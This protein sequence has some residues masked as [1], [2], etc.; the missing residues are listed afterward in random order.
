MTCKPVS[1]KSRA[2]RVTDTAPRE[3]HMAAVWPPACLWAG[4]LGTVR[5]KAGVFVVDIAGGDVRQ[6]LCLLHNAPRCRKIN[7]W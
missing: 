3:R 4:S 1:S 5:T 7:W 6:W 2:L